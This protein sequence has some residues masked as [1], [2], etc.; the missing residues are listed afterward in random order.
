MERTI[1]QDTT[2][3]ESVLPIDS[4]RPKIMFYKSPQLQQTPALFPRKNI[5]N[6]EPPYS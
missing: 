6:R 4:E 3:T 2:G 5:E 1:A